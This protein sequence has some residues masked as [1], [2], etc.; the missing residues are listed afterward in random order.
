MT[1]GIIGL[2]L[3]GGSLAKAYKRNPHITVYGLDTN[4]SVQDFALLSEAIDNSLSSENIKSCDLILLAVPVGAALKWLNENA[5]LISP[6]T[7]VMDCCGT[8][9]KICEAGFALAKKHGFEFA[10][11]HPMA[12]IH[13]WGVKNSSAKLFDGAC[14]VIVPRTFDDMD[15]LEH[16]KNL[17]LPAGFENISIT[18]A[19]KH[20]KIIAFTSQLAHVV[21]NAYVKS[22]VVLNHKGFS[23]GS[24]QDLTRVAWLN[25]D[26]WA[27]L[28]LEN[29]DNL[30]FELDMIINSL[31]EYKKAIEKD[32][33]P[34]L[35]SLLND[36]RK[37]KKEIDGQNKPIPKCN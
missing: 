35:V 1:V 18:T 10:G 4:K 33:R 21:S 2:G 15:L 23:A 32:D 34:F 24:Y 8:K 37:R 5:E 6:H 11:G 30:L 28:F 13:E 16:I 14:M 25:P 31:N 27:D 19:E 7:I 20:D 36:G 12:G 26:M 3:I 29:K 9:R 22:P 17:V